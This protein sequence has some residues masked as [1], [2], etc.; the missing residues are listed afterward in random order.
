MNWIVVQIDPLTGAI[1]NQSPGLCTS[2]AAGLAYDPVTNLLYA[3]KK[4]CL[5]NWNLS[6]GLVGL[7]PHRRNIVSTGLKHLFTAR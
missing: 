5:F 2:L 1:L 6:C 3:S 7:L 4:G